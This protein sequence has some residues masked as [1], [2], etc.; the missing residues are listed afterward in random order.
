MKQLPHQQQRAL[1]LDPRAVFKAAAPPPPPPPPPRTVV[2]RPHT[3]SLNLLVSRASSV[4]RDWLEQLLEL[5]IEQPP[6]PLSLLHRLA[7][8]CVLVQRLGVPSPVLRASTRY[9]RAGTLLCTCLY[10]A[11]HTKFANQLAYN[12]VHRKSASP[13]RATVFHGAAAIASRRRDERAAAVVVV[14]VA[15]VASSPARTS[16]ARPRACHPGRAQRCGGRRPRQTPAASA[17]RWRAGRSGAARVGPPRDF[18]SA[19]CDWIRAAVAI[20]TMRLQL[21]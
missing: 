13:L 3:P 16:R 21:H 17:C 10:T 8:A 9:R 2:H 7:R 15:V 12:R 19:C 18:G 20:V 1:P 11:T 14:V 4:S 5:R 6:V